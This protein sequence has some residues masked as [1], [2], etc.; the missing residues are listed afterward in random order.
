M[1]HLQASFA[2][3]VDVPPI[4]SAKRIKTKDAEIETDEVEQWERGTRM[5]GRTDAE[6]QTEVIEI[7]ETEV[8]LSEF[9][10]KVG[11]LMLDQLARTTRAFQ[12][13]RYCRLRGH[14]GRRQSAQSTAA[15]P[16]SS[17]H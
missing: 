3:A 16:C 4:V 14:L 13:K 17:C 7:E 9:M 11:P 2:E 6:C 15:L 5:A 8:D 1:S 10:R 12:C